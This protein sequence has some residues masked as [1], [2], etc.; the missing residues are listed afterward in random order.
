MGIGMTKRAIVGHRRTPRNNQVRANIRDISDNFRQ[1]RPCARVATM[2]RLDRQTAL[3]AALHRFGMV[4]GP[5]PAA[6]RLPGMTEP[7]ASWVLGIYRDLGGTLTSPILRPGGWDIPTAGGLIVELD[8]EQHF[9]RYRVTT[10]Q[11]DWTSVLPWADEY[12]T[13]GVD[14]EKTALKSHSSGGFWQSDGS[15]AQYGPAAPRGD[16]DGAG[17]PRWKQRALYDAMRDAS[18][19]AGIVTLARLSVYDIVGNARLG[20]ALSGRGHLDAGA[21]L[22]LIARRTSGTAGSTA[23]SSVPGNHLETWP[24]EIVRE[25]PHREPKELRAAPMTVAEIAQVLERDPKAIRAAL[26]AEYGKLTTDSNWVI[27]AEKATFLRS[28]FGQR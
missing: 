12:R 9:N 20:D 13:Y 23:A 1:R 3:A 25:S 15:M 16:L 2:T 14:H 21:L 8:E 6:P 17:S 18:A 19:A 28:R 22:D 10:L 11:A 24:A 7:A 27:D 5:P 26:R 4:A